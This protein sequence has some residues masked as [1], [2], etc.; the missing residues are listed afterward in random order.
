MSY[1]KKT[2]EKLIALPSPG[3]YEDQAQQFVRGELNKYCDRVDSDIYGDVL[4]VLNEKAPT[5]ILLAAHI[6]EIALVV[7]NIDKDGFVN[8]NSLGGCRPDALVGQ[9][10]KVYSGKKTVPGVI[11]R[12]HGPAPKEE[13]TF[14][15]LYVDIGARSKADALKMISVGDMITPSCTLDYL[16]NNRVAGRGLDDRCGVAAILDAMRIIKAAKGVPKVAVY[17]LSNVQEECGRFRGATI[18][19]FQIAPQAAIAIDVCYA[20]DFPKT[21]TQL[22]GDCQVGSGPTLSISVTCNRV[23]NKQLESAAK[24]KKIPLQYAVAPSSTGTDGDAIASV[25]PGVATGVVSIPCRYVHSPSEVISLK[26]LANTA[27]LLAEFVLRMPAKP[28]FKPF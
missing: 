7:S 6:D 12:A 23:V 25:G 8:V 4:G 28:N 20:R 5:K 11:G 24:S 15:H 3:T 2:L 27:K 13:L 22:A 18:S 14:K 10:V 9:R 26:D 16:A 21:S 19:T 1:L 17:A